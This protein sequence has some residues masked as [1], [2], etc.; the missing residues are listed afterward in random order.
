MEKLIELKLASGITHAG[1][2]KD[3]AD[4]QE[5]IRILK[6]NAEFAQRLDPFVRARF[7]E[8]RVGAA[9]ASSDD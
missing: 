6:L 8:L 1:R 2:I 7:E 3:L 4:V 5:L 9:S